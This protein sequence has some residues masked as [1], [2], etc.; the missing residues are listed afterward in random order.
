M[1]GLLTA[2]LEDVRQEYVDRV[3]ANRGA[4]PYLIAERLVHEKLFFNADQ[5]T[6]ILKEDPS[7]LAA[8]AGD[9]IMNQQE[10]ANPSVGVIICSNI[11]AAALEGL[12]A[13]AVE[14]DWLDVDDQGLVLVDEEELSQN[15]Q[16]P[17]EVDFSQSEV[18]KANLAA[19]GISEMS[20]IFGAAEAAFVDAL[21]EQNSQ[22]DAYQLALDISSDYSV[23]A[24]E[25][26]MPLVAENPLLLGL[27]TDDLIDEDLFDGDPPAGLIISAHLTRMMLHQLLELGVEQGALVLDSTGHI[28]VPD[29][30]EEPPTIH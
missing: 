9:L 16:Y 18:A 29:E 4:E 2:L 17:I 7:L 28:V 10:S 26:I 15:S 3:V 6:E 24:P 19:G 5:L 20:H 14:R 23:F 13:V 27:R 25:D 12:L 22:R 1:S 8:R 30:P 21:R 11:V